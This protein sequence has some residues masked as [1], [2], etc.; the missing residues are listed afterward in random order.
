MEDL[1]TIFAELKKYKVVSIIGLSKNV[2]KTTTLNHIIKFSKGKLTLGLTSIG[3]DG[4]EYDVITQLPKPRIMVDSGTILA[5]A[6]QSLQNSNIESEL[7]KETRINTPMGEIQIVRSLNSGLVEL[8]GPSKNSEVKH[9]CDQ[10]LELGCD[11]VLIDGAFDRRSYATPLIS[12]AT[13]LST[14]ASVMRDMQK[15][16]DITKHIFNLLTLEREKNVDVIKI[17]NKAISITKVGIINSDFLVKRL[18]MLTALDSIEEILTQLDA[19]SKYLVVNGAITDVF[20]EELIKN[21]DIYKNTTILVP[22]ATKL[23]LSK[24]TFDKYSKKGGIIRVLNE[25]KI[26]MIT[27]NPMS[28]LG[29]QFDKSKFLSELKK[30]LS[31]PIYDL[32][33]SEY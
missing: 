27:V 11:L 21:S 10:L 14:G 8:A 9:V 19:T 7:L 3:R 18:N 28:P 24:G 12:Q 1:N 29:Y 4:E 15:V 32:G 23:F 13:I 30:G 20:L 17:A 26:I 5:T 31:V 6:F 2:S 22:D 33:P 16:V 25:I